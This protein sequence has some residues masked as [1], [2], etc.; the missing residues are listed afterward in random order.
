MTFTRQPPSVQAQA[1]AA[2][3]YAKETLESQGWQVESLDGITLRAKATHLI[4]HGMRPSDVC[5]ILV[6]EYPD[7]H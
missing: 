7:G 1:W 6:N 4:E 3:T 5:D 2:V